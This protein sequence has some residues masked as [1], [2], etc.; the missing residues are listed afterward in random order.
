MIMAL[1]LSNKE[2]IAMGESQSIMMQT[3][4]KNSS[5]QGN[6]KR[7][8]KPAVAGVPPQEFL[9]NS[10]LVYLSNRDAKS[11]ERSAENNA[12]NRSRGD[13]KNG[14]TNESKVFVRLAQQADIYHNLQKQKRELQ[15]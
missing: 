6:L 15:D 13:S 8:D 14:S 5:S 11:R 9:T 2:N 4:F 7:N 1:T 10:R 12:N 3:S